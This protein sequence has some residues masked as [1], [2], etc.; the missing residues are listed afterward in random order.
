MTG[1]LEGFA[2]EIEFQ[3]C[4]RME[5]L[6]AEVRKRGERGERQ[7]ERERG[8]R[9]TITINAASITVRRRKSMNVP[10]AKQWKPNF[11]G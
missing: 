9:S 5:F 8:V 6:G 4:G 2:M 3:L 10:A 11:R 1:S 7:R